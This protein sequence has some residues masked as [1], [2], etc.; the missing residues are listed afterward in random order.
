MD[1]T[2]TMPKCPHCD[3][4]YNI[5]FASVLRGEDGLSVTRCIVDCECSHHSVVIDGHN[6]G[7]V[8]DA[9]KIERR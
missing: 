5:T 6:V 4:E 7:H 9:L 3:A 1:K 8:L 2:M